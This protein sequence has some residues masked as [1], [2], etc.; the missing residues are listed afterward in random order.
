MILKFDHISFVASRD[1]VGM[2]LADKGEPVFKEI[3]LR[4]IVNKFPLMRG[5]SVNHDMYFYDRG[6]IPTEYIFYDAVYGQSQ[7][8]IS[9]TIINGHYKEE[10]KAVDF[11]SSIFRN[12]VYVDQGKI[13]CKV[14]GIM[15]KKD[16]EVVLTQEKNYF[17]ERNYLD[18]HGYGVAAIL[19]QGEMN[20]DYWTEENQLIVNGKN[21][22]ISFAACDS[23]DL[24]FEMIR[25]G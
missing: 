20:K 18:T 1:D 2:V 3:R 19:Y 15:D 13:K 21:L 16:Y 6:G 10:T 17:E 9:S 23:V 12:R 22:F 7:I 5:K 24:I 11:L 25:I 8:T 4:N 14:S